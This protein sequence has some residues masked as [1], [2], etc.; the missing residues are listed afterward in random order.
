[1][2][3]K[4]L[5]FIIFSSVFI[6]NSFSQITDCGYKN[7]NSEVPVYET[8]LQGKAFYNQHPNKDKQFYNNWAKADIYLTN[9]TLVKNKLLRYNALL[10]EML[11]MR[12]EDFQIIILNRK[13][14]ASVYFYTENNNMPTKYIKIDHKNLQHPNNSNMF[15]QLLSDVDGKVQFLKK[16]EVAENTNDMKLEKTERYYIYKNNEYKR[17]VLGKLFL[18]K[19]F[20]NNKKHIKQIIDDNKLSAKKEQ[21]LIKAIHIFNQT[22]Q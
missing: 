9:N 11:W 21:D 22:Y 2:K 12:E 13:N 18:Y 20:G 17:L 19:L 16:I 5:L 1:M 10:D 8:T 14:I 3:L 7:I 15:V 6:S 4:L